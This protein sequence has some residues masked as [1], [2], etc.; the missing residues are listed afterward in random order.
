MELEEKRRRQ[1]VEHEERMRRMLGHLFQRESYY[2]YNIQ[3][4]SFDDY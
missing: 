2:H 3:E 1:D 4:Y